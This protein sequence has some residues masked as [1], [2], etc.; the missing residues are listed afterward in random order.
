MFRLS[1]LGQQ[2]LIASQPA[3]GLQDAREMSC[4]GCRPT[5]RHL[6]SQPELAQH[7]GLPW[8]NPECPVIMIECEEGREEV[9]QAG[10][11]GLQASSFF[12]RAEAMLALR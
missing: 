11:V 4:Q 9:A 2:L 1:K 3:A 6:S 7:A 12:N 8:P 5:R 10:N